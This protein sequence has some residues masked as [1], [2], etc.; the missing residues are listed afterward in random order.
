MK[1]SDS[2]GIK[3]LKPTENSNLFLTLPLEIITSV[4]PLVTK[5]DYS[6]V[7]LAATCQ[8]FRNLPHS[9]FSKLL[10][11]QTSSVTQQ[12]RVL[13]GTSE[14]SLFNRYFKNI[15]ATPV[16]NFQKTLVNSSDE[17]K[18]NLIRGVKFD[19]NKMEVFLNFLAKKGL[20]EELR[21]LFES[22]KENEK[23]LALSSDDYR[24]VYNSVLSNNLE[25]VKYLFEQ[26]EK[27]GI[28][29]EA[30]SAQAYRVFDRNCNPELME[31]LLKKLEEKKEWLMEDLFKNNYEGLLEII[32]WTK[33]PP[34]LKY[35]LK[36]EKKN[37]W[38]EALSIK[39]YKAF[40]HLIPYLD[41]PEI[42]DPT[43]KLLKEKGKLVEA[44]SSNDYKVFSD[45]VFTGKPKLLKYLLETLEAEGGNIVEALFNNNYEIFKAAISDGNLELLKYLFKKLE[46]KG[47]KQ[48]EVLLSNDVQNFLKDNN[49]DINNTES[50][51]YLLEKLEGTGKESDALL[52]YKFFIAAIRNNDLKLMEYL[53]NQFNKKGMLTKVVFDNKDII[54]GIAVSSEK[55]T[56]V[57]FLF[58]KLEEY[59]VG[60]EV[61][62]N[63]HF[64]ELAASNPY[65]KVIKYLFEKLESQGIEKEALR[66][67]GY[68]I[69]STLISDPFKTKY[70]LKKL[71]EKKMLVEALS[72]NGYHFF[73]NAI[74]SGNLSFVRY[75]FEK[76]EAEGKG[77]E[78]LSF[79]N[80]RA[81]HIAI[82]IA[83]NKENGRFPCLEVTKYLFEQLEKNGMVPDALKTFSQSTT[84]LPQLFLMS[85]LPEFKYLWRIPRWS[86]SEERMIN[87]WCMNNQWI[88]QALSLFIEF[89][90]KVIPH[91]PFDN[92]V[93]KYKEVIDTT[94]SINIL[95]PSRALSQNLIYLLI[96]FLQK[97]RFIPETSL[98]NSSNEWVEAIKSILDQNEHFEGVTVE[99]QEL[100]L[101]YFQQKKNPLVLLKEIREAWGVEDDEKDNMTIQLSKAP[102]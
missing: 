87:L 65:T 80:Y 22:L 38:L 43:L 82:N 51:L 48:E 23:Q 68:Q 34:L 86:P 58:K 96:N 77:S 25:L 12:N 100:L 81:F 71:E 79:F 99:F 50:V 52:N 46:E 33:S 6:L 89:F 32:E 26:L 53:F 3:K 18:H 4:L 42:Q 31:Y 62:S 44:L 8:F 76:L 59:G 36:L 47:I 20:L 88:K 2:T 49:T 7:L 5:D 69:L 57:E 75:L 74:L 63:N 39:N 64:F 95:Q 35:L 93:D 85:Y 11:T 66:A 10:K 41:D 17:D 67:G 27:K 40:H 21:N 56:T 92:Y 19:V 73:H 98:F 101:K 60:N 84:I 16:I 70:L 30:L 72:I 55:Q 45:L 37:E 78:A 24:I 97:S 28:E 54:F 13:K 14:F 9:N 83:I 94:G 102:F 1:E 91:I 15:Y 29:K 90:E 61:L